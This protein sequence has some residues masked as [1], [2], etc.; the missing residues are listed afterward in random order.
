LICPSDR[1]LQFF[2]GG[3]D[4][5]KHSSPML[6]LIFYLIAVMALLQ[7]CSAVGIGPA[8]LEASPGNAADA[9]EYAVYSSIVKSMY[10]GGTVSM[11][12]ILDETCAIHKRV[13]YLF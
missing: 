11:I 4:I 3:I 9:E 6:H 10:I 12:A 2:N 5:S 8:K 13:E 1:A 7:S